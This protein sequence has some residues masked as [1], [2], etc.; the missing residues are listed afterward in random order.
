MQKNK[1]LPSANYIKHA[2]K[3]MSWQPIIRNG[4]IIKFSVFDSG[5]SI[6]LLF[7]SNHTGHT[8]I[9]SFTDEDDAVNFINYVVQLDPAEYI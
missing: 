3:T 8:I 7:V 4:W 5:S 6:L 2:V 9:R 1:I